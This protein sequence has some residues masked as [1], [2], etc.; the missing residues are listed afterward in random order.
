MHL[1]G[2]LVRLLVARF[3][4]WRQ[5]VVKAIC[6]QDIAKMTKISLDLVVLVSYT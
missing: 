4:L 1:F 6:D 3:N 2:R 5:T